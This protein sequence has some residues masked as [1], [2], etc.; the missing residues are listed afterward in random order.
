MGGLMDVINDIYYSKSN[1]SLYMREWV[2]VVGLVDMRVLAII[3]FCLT[4][5]VGLMIVV[6]GGKRVL[7]FSGLKGW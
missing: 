2:V 4:K 1:V 3:L 7:P 6:E 5:W